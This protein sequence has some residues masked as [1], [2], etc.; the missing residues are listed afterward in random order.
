MRVPT[1][2][3]AALVSTGRV[4]CLTHN[5]ATVETALEELTRRAAP[6]LDRRDHLREEH[7]RLHRHA[8]TNRRLLRALDDHETTVAVAQATVDALDTWKHWATGQ[9][10][11]PEQLADAVDVLHHTDRADH[12]A[13][14]APLA[15]GWT[16]I[17][18]HRNGRP[19]NS[20]GHISN[21]RASRSASDDRR[22]SAT[23]R[24]RPDSLRSV[25]PIGSFDAAPTVGAG[26]VGRDRIWRHRS[27]RR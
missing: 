20:P 1:W 4:V 18:S 21:D 17:S 3:L 19:S 24:L 16:N 9:K 27:R 10:I 26:P 15:H 2:A 11:W 6:M 13:L 23:T 25:S 22:T 5:L 7:D 12:T 8:T 14:A